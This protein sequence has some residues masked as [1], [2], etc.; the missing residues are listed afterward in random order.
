MTTST[1]VFA[2]DGEM[3]YYG[4]IV[5]PAYAVSSSYSLTNW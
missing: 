3:Q 5:M 4:L 1:Q 2:E